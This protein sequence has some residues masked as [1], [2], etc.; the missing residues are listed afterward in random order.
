M[1]LMQKLALQAKGDPKRVAFPE[2]ANEMILKCAEQLVLEGYG[3]PLLVGNPAAVQTAAGACGVSVEGFAYFDNTDEAA[4]EQ[5][6]AD[7]TARYDDFSEKAVRRKAKDGVNCAMFLC[8]LGRVDCVAAG[9]EYTTADVILA[10]QTIG[11]MEP[12][13]NAIS[14][15]GILNIPG[16]EGPEKN[17]LA[18][19]DCAIN[20]APDAADL[21]DI[22]IAS[23]DTVSSLLGW[24]PRVA[25][26]A[27]S[28]CG[29]SEH[30]SLD[31][32]RQAIEIAQ[33]RRPGL[34]ID[35]EFQFDS[36]IIP[37][38]AAKKV[39]RESD[40]AGKAN[41][42]IFP[43]LH[44]GNIGVK[45]FQYIGHADAYGPVL[46]GFA[47]PVCDFSRGAPLSEMMGNIIMLIVRAQ[48]KK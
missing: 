13:V 23:A 39:Q 29:S 8:K 47:Y 9:R 31:V 4:L 45:I 6:V 40:V 34:K 36:A 28:T 20:M 32:I 19:A 37:G 1:D 3:K 2:S 21:A 25:M 17:M 7:Y 33:G 16:F 48:A 5:L 15:L 14:S 41:V 24:E 43:N 46:Q 12:G 27:F 26:L 11:G 44:A 38:V 18:I 35:G 22:A 10:A 30:E 42:L